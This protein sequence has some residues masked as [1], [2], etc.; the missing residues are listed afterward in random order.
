MIGFWGD[1]LAYAVPFIAGGI[2][3]LTKVI[4]LSGE[5]LKKLYLNLNSRRHGG[6]EGGRED[7]FG[8]DGVEDG[9]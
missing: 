1:V 3:Y 4:R 6:G 7:V 9:L 5:G 2:F 8:F